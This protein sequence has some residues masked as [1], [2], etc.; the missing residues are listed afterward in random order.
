VSF[1]FVEEAEITEMED[2]TF[3]A[4]VEP[5]DEFEGQC[6]VRID[7]LKVERNVSE[8]KLWNNRRFGGPFSPSLLIKC[9]FYVLKF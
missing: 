8:E 3:R 2:A 5:I 9:I 1:N 6:N 7:K 4:D